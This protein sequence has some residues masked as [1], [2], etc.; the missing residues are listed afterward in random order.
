[1]TKLSTLLPLLF[2]STGACLTV[3]AHDEAAPAKVTPT[4]SAAVNSI[5]AHAHDVLTRLCDDF[6]GRLTGSP[7]NE[8]ALNRLADE[9]S[10]LG[11]EPKRQQFS[12][13]GWERGIDQVTMTAPFTRALRAAAMGY[14][15]ASA[16][17]SGKV[18]FVGRGAESEWPE[19]DLDGAIGLVASGSPVATSELG[20]MAAHRNLAALLLINREAGGQLLMRTGSH[21]GQSLPVPTFT[22]TVEEGRWIQRLLERD[23]EVVVEVSSTS[24]PLETHT[25]NLIVTLPGKSA[26]RVIVGAH[27]DSWDLGQGAIDNGLGL[28][29]VFAVAAELRSRELARTVELVWFN[30][31]EQGLWGSRH[32]ASELGDAPIVA[33]INL[34]MVGVPIAVNAL[35]F[36]A[37]VPVLERWNTG[38]GEQKL[39]QGVLNSNWLGSDHIPYQLAGV[40]TVT[41]HAPIERESVR[42]YHDFADTMDK[43]PLSLLAE[44]S[45]IITDLV[46]ALANDTSLQPRR[47][48]SAEIQAHFTRDGLDKRLHRMGWWQFE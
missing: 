25:E 16:K 44:S 48:T 35:G 15:P 12:M 5:A 6:G 28:A 26:E 46:E 23:T 2:I 42:Y 10:A 20:A 13:P 27:F 4:E 8:A 7:A 30:G 1:M 9:L 11:L 24:R 14:S 21:A 34:D 45:A 29:Q 47:Y 36:D 3:L 41:F 32:A 31:E 40:P 33:M 18:V 22:I 19:G 17:V 38:R 43:L 39:P 37:L